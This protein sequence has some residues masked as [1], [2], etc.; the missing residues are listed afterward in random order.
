MQ[1]TIT[2]LYPDADHAAS[3]KI[4]QERTSQ[5]RGFSFTRDHVKAVEQLESAKHY[6]LYFLFDASESVSSKVYIGQS[7]NGVGRMTDHVRNK[8]F[9]THCL[10]F[11]TDNNSFDKS[12]IDY[13]EYAFIGKFKDSRYR[14]V[15]KDMRMTA[16]NVIYSDKPNLDEYIRQISFLLRAEGISLTQKPKHKLPASKEWFTYDPEDGPVYQPGGKNYRAAMQVREGEF[17]LLAG[18]ILKRPKTNGKMAESALSKRNNRIIDD[19]LD[20]GKV[21]EEDGRYTLTVDIPFASPSGPAALITGGSTNG[22]DFFKGLNDLRK[23]EETADSL[24]AQEGE[25]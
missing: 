10:M 21:I 11:V 25:R 17:V 22:W 14:L 19:Y 5:I 16:P 9:W 6:A 24:S 3:L 8:D 13:M 1:R 7:V 2:Y 20:N 18:S 4:F 12:A 15:N 23:L